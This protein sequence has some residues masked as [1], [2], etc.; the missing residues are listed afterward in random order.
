MSMAYVRPSGGLLSEMCT[1]IQVLQHFLKGHIEAIL[2]IGSH[3]DELAVF[4]FFQNVEF[5]DTS[6]AKSLILL[7]YK[8][9]KDLSCAFFPYYLSAK[10]KIPSLQFFGGCRSWALWGGRGG[11]EI[12]LWNTLVYFTLV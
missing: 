10:L 1:I 5:C 11:L 7:M 9:H 4:H 12:L 2:T 3:H 8:D 6:A